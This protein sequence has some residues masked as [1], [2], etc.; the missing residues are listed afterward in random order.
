MSIGFFPPLYPE[1]DFRSLIY[2]FHRRSGNENIVQTNIDLFEMASTTI[3]LKN[4]VTFIEKVKITNL[5]EIIENHTLF[6]LV[7]P[8]VNLEQREQLYNR[9]TNNTKY[10]D[11]Y[12]SL[13]S[14]L[15]DSI[16]YCPICV[17]EDFSKFGEVN[18]KTFHQCIFFKTCYIHGV[19]LITKCQSCGGKFE[20]VES[21]GKPTYLT[22]NSC[23][24]CGEKINQPP[25]IVQDQIERSILEDIKYIINNNDKFILESL[26]IK[27]MAWMYEKGY[28]KTT[29][30]LNINLKKLIDDLYGFYGEEFFKK[31]DIDKEGLL[32][33]GH[34]S[35]ILFGKLPS[36]KPFLHIIF[37]RFISKSSVENFINLAVPS[38][39]QTVPFG[40]GPWEC[41]NNICENYR[42]KVIKKCLRTISRWDRTRGEFVCP[43]CGFHYMKS[44]DVVSEVEKS[45]YSIIDH[46]SLITD[47]II[48]V[49][50]QT[51][52]I[53]QTSKITGISKVTVKKIIPKVVRDYSKKLFEDKE[54]AL[55]MS[56]VIEVYF[57]CMS[58]RETA[59]QTGAE[60]RTVRKY[61]D[62]MNTC[63]LNLIQIQEIA[64]SLHNGDLT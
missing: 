22:T 4:L 49:Y 48:E 9:I 44:W 11:F 7:Y 17:N 3:Q 20:T 43:S 39:F 26:R 56:K 61:I 42:K 38:V 30:E 18:F 12:S 35:R 24:R 60:R 50:G 21:Y 52:N 33:G 63:N 41:L 23:K 14:V 46:G 10:R 25:I 1:E 40:H 32:K 29:M 57:D 34:L 45:S 51:N 27:Y 5:L 31:F 64:V 54:L 16:R 62:I 47:S 2:R 15:S 6:P 28:T 8:F 13:P 36:K 19:E 37:M 59:R 58:I 55:R 53:E